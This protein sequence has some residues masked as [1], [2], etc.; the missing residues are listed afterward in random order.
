MSTEDFFPY[1]TFFV[2]LH[3]NMT[4][5]GN[6]PIK[7]HNVK[8][9]NILLHCTYL[10]SHIHKTEI[11]SSL[12]TLIL[13][14][15]TY[16]HFCNVCNFLLHLETFYFYNLTKKDFLFVVLWRFFFSLPCKFEHEKLCLPFSQCFTLQLQIIFSGCC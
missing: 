4:V 2:W 1:T 14:Y 9:G 6:M 15:S 7:M 12:L 3:L 5:N 11:K 16:V 13:L 8:C 10:H